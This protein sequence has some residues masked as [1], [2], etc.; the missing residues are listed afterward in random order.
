M[1]RFSKWPISDF[2]GNVAESGQDGS[3]DPYEYAGMLLSFL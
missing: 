1:I 2:S 3:M